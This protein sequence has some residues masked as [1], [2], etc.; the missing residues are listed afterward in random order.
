MVPNAF[1]TWAAVPE[2]EMVI[3]S[4][5][6]APTLKPSLASHARAVLTVL[7]AGENRD[8]HWEAVR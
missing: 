3:R 8:S 7:V 5:D 4:L 2:A 1:S 6:T